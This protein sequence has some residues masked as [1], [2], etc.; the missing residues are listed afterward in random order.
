[1]LH[2][3]SDGST[4][5]IDRGRELSFTKLYDRVEQPIEQGIVVLNV[6]IG[7]ALEFIKKNKWKEIRNNVVQRFF[8]KGIWG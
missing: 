3:Y 6:R 1:M 8:V 2:E 7:A 5:L 4:N